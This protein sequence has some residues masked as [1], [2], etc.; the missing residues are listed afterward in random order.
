MDIERTIYKKYALNG[1]NPKDV[2]AHIQSLLE[3]EQAEYDRLKE[4]LHKE[5]IENQRL[6]EEL[7]RKEQIP[8]M[9]PIAEEISGM[10]M[11][12]FVA[13]TQSILDLQN[14]LQEKEE[15][16]LQQLEIKTQQSEMAKNRI[17][18]V[19]EYV[20]AIMEKSEKELKDI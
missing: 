9:N 20:K 15:Q 18:E 2:R 8:P 13:H 14:E 3:S 17:K 1:Y 19:P 7:E 11:D 6:L 10:L 4:K 5:K 12:L 16:Q